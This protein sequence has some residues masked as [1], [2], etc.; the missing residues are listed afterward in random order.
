MKAEDLFQSSPVPLS[1]ASLSHTNSV[2]TSNVYL[3]RTFILAFN[4][5]VWA[6]QFAKLSHIIDIHGFRT[7]DNN[8]ND[9]DDDYNYNNI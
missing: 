5:S 9:D 6:I 2:Y 3:F 1:A 4:R 8:G 7:G